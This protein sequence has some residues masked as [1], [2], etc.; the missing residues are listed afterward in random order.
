MTVL[1]GAGVLQTFLFNQRW[2]FRGRGPG[3]AALVR[4]CIA[5]TSGYAM[6]YLILAVFVDYLGLAHQYVQGVVII[7]LT[8]YLF[9]LQRM[10]VF[11]SYGAQA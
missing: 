8:L 7:M 6:N 4:Y 11:R 5:Y 9:I 1:Y 10:W 3:G 2:S